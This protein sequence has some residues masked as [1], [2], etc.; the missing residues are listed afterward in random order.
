M[1]RLPN[2]RSLLQP[3]TTT[4]SHAATTPPG[5]AV[6][7]GGVA[8]DHSHGCT[9]RSRRQAGDGQGEVL[10]KVGLA[11]CPELRL[12]SVLR[13]QQVRARHFIDMLPQQLCRE[14]RQNTS[15]DILQVH[16]LVET[17]LCCH[18]FLH[19]A[20]ALYIQPQVLCISFF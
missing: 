3:S 6:G 8:E 11:G 12:P 9:N 19:V 15:V 10:E 14:K 18:S 20:T 5:G 4:A 17:Y 1:H 2:I 13:L 16:V 7:T